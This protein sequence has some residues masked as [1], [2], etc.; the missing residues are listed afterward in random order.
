MLLMLTGLTASSNEVS[1][2]QLAQ[3]HEVQEA[4]VAAEFDVEMDE[5]DNLIELDEIHPDIDFSPKYKIKQNKNIKPASYAPKKEDTGL[6]VEHG[7]FSLT[8]TSKKGQN[9]YMRENL[10][11][12][13]EAKWNQKYFELST[14][15]ETKYE[16]V[17]AS[18]NSQNVFLAPKLKLGDRFSVLYNS[19]VNPYSLTTEQEVGVN[20]KPKSIENS[21]FGVTT[22]STFLN[23]VETSKKMRFISDF[24]LW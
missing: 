12:R 9:D 19:K 23:G 13:T 7:N 20:Y 22:G 4:P 3:L 16:S 10:R 14:G 1:Y 2:L 18:K 8:S 17:D 15:M 21:S 6:N 24:Y 11:Q 5:F